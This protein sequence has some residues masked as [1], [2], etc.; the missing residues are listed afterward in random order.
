M[1]PVIDNLDIVCGVFQERFLIG[2]S[3]YV[4]ILMFFFVNL[5]CRLPKKNGSESLLNP[6]NKFDWIEIV[7]NNSRRQLD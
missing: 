1:V 6:G 3:V 5:P 4:V 2:D 7:G